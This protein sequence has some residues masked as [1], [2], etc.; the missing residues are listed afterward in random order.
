MTQQE[1]TEREAPTRVTKAATKR[2]TREIIAGEQATGS[3]AGFS[4][5][6]SHANASARKS[7]PSTSRARHTASRAEEGT[8]KN[9]Q[10]LPKQ[11]RSR[12][13]SRG[14]RAHKQQSSCHVIRTGQQFVNTLQSFQTCRG[15]GGSPNFHT[16]E[17]DGFKAAFDDPQF[18]IDRDPYIT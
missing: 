5:Q 17:Q 13:T 15:N 6:G 10:V 16:I 1:P 3:L 4:T 11:S 14:G 8:G 7:E 2:D 18:G 9:E 12:A